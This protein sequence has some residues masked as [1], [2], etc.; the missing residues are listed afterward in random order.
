LFFFYYYKETDLCL[1][2]WKNFNF[3]HVGLLFLK[4]SHVI[5]TN[6][7]HWWT[8][9]SRVTHKT[10][11]L[12]SYRLL[13]CAS[14]VPAKF[15]PGFNSTDNTAGTKAAKMNIRRY[16]TCTS[17]GYGKTC[18]ATFYRGE[19]RYQFSTALTGLNSEHIRSL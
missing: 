8:Y 10:S 14:I 18:L 3:L 16:T 12:T 5:T 17:Y 19:H 13:G 15:N 2:L 11:K 4:S 9:M 6:H 1:C 7:A